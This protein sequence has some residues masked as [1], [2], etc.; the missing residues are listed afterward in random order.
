MPIMSQD[1]ATDHAPYHPAYLTNIN[2]RISISC[3]LLGQGQTTHV[4]HTVAG[5]TMDP[6]KAEL[7]TNPFEV[8]LG[9]H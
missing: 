9:I 1:P 8:G 7:V 3:Q 4:T 6:L 2:L 5:Q